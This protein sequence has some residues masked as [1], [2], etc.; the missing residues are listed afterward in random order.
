MENID[1]GNLNGAPVREWRARSQEKDGPPGL[2][3]TGRIANWSARHKWWVVSASVMFIVLAMFVLNTVETKTLD[4]N[5]EGD[6]AIG[7]DLIADRFNTVPVPTEQL[8]FSNPTL[9]ANSLTYRAVVNSLVRQLRSLPEVESVTSFYDTRDPNMVSEDGSVVLAQVVI[10]GDADDATDKVDAI[11]D[12]VR[13]SGATAE[14]FEITMA[15]SSS[16]EKQL[17]DIDEEDFDI[18]IMGSDVNSRHQTSHV[19]GSP[20]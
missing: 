10:A 1:S 2:S 4:Y 19:A 7:A 18:M 16:I 9:D 8:V 5:G 13:E 11:L 6:S 20:A 12:K 14:G 3:V 15:G 17:E